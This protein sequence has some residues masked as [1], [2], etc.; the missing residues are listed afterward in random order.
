MHSLT[1]PILSA[2][3]ICEY[4]EK[5][6]QATIRTKTENC[7]KILVARKAKKTSLELRRSNAALAS[8]SAC[9]YWGFATDTGERKVWKR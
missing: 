3:L 4:G 7:G 6:G 8:T 1:S 2:L 5:G 9:P